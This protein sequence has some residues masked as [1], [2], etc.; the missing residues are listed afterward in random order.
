MYAYD[1]AKSLKLYARTRGCQFVATECVNCN[2]KK[3][4]SL[5]FVLCVN[6][7]QNSFLVCVLSREFPPEVVH[8][9][10]AV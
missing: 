1:S 3:R 8:C 10:P 9:S 5:V 2:K 6:N 7:L 4:A